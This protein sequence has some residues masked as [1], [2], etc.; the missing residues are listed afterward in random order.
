[1][2]NL[3]SGFWTFAEGIAAVLAILGGI[4]AAYKLI[5]E[6]PFTRPLQI[7]SGNDSTR[8]VLLELRGKTIRFDTVLDF[9]VWNG[10]TCR[11]ASDTEY[12]KILSRPASELNNKTLPL[13]VVRNDCLDSFAS[14]IISMKDS[15]R[16][17]FSH[18]G[19]GVTQVLLTG[20]L[21][22]E[23]REYSGPSVEIT[24]REVP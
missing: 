6:R 21:S 5:R 1:M 20:K 4:Y 23:V 7:F 14:L 12:Q 19:T 16:L 22:V 24:L 3:I 10:L 2:E 17:K 13:Y 11:I 15:R 18:G 8:D 9:S